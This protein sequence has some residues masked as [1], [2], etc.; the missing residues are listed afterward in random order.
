MKNEMSLLSTLHLFHMDDHHLR[1]TSKNAT[2]LHSRRIGSFDFSTMF[3]II[4]G[5]L[6]DSLHILQAILCEERY[7]VVPFLSNIV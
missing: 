3:S 1:K 4:D 2:S 5:L 7:I 6:R